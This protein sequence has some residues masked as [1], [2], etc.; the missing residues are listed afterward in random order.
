[1]R[2]LGSGAA[3]GEVLLDGI[4]VFCGVVFAVSLFHYSWSK[5]ENLSERARIERVYQQYTKS[6]LSIYDGVSRIVVK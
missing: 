5:E 4:F 1:M 6:N 3:G 2:Q